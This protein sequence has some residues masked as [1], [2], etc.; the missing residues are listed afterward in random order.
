MTDPA[1]RWIVGRAL[2]PRG[3]GVASAYDRITE[4]IGAGDPMDATAIF[5]EPRKGAKNRLR[6]RGE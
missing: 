1:M 4:R 5:D 6:R 3:K 2:A